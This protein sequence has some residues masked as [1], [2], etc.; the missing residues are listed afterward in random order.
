MSMFL[1][2]L[3]RCAPSLCP[4]QERNLI[5]GI[6]FARSLVVA[7]ELSQAE[8]HLNQVTRQWRKSL[9]WGSGS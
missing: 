9:G 2:L 7:A 3:C 5:P 1:T 8:V 4:R 6:D